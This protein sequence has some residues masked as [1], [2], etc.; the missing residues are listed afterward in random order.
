MIADTIIII[1]IV[2]SPADTIKKEP[3]KIDMQ[4]L[5]KASDR[6]ASKAYELTKNNLEKMRRLKYPHIIPSDVK[7]QGRG[8]G[9]EKITDKYDEQFPFSYFEEFLEMLFHSS[10]DWANIDDLGFLTVAFR[11]L[12]SITDKDITKVCEFINKLE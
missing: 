10:V 6:A 4:K 2:L 1:M 3:V 12:P 5:R 8:F 7:I 9:I 11:I